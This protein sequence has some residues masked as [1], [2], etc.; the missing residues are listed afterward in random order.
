MASYVIEIEDS[1]IEEQIGR[2]LDAELKEQLRG[3]Y[4]AVGR[5]ISDAVKELVYAHKDEILEMVVE[6]ASREMVKKGLP[7]LLERMGGSECC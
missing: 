1:K 6:R 4:T 2:I 7:K 3:R 5:E